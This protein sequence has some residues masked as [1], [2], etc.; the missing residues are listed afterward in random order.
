MVLTHSISGNIASHGFYPSGGGNRILLGDQLH[1][2][3]STKRNFRRT[4]EYGVSQHVQSQ[5]LFTCLAQGYQS[6]LNLSVS[7]LVKTAINTAITVKQ[8]KS[9][10][11]LLSMCKNG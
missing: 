4:R 6:Y 5:T 10:V 8:L 1:T 9:K 7:K 3:A 11:T 2:R